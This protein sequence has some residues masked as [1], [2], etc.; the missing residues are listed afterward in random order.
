MYMHM[1]VHV[2]MYVCV[3]YL[4][5]SEQLLVLDLRLQVL[6]I[7]VLLRLEESGDRGIG[8]RIRGRNEW[9]VV[10]GKG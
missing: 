1:C 9:G 3:R 2:C 4:G 5:L 10:G 8:A 6:V 7:G